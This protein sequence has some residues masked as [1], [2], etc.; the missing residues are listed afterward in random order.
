MAVLSPEF[1]RGGLRPLRHLGQGH[2]LLKPKAT[3]TEFRKGTPLVVNMRDG[4]VM[5]D[6]FTEKKSGAVILARAG[7]VPLSRVRAISIERKK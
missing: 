5:R 1:I 7:R 6:R 2:R 4:T 3:H